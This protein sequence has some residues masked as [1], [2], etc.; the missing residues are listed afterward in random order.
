MATKL[1][2]EKIRITIPVWQVE[3]IKRN[4]PTHKRS[5]LIRTLIKDHIAASEVFKQPNFKEKANG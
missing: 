3:W 5:W 1:P 4:I 2:M